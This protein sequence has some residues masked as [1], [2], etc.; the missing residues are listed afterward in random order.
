[1]VDMHCHLLFGVDDGPKMIE[2]SICILKKAKQ[3]GVTDMIVTPHAFSPRYH[4]S[5]SEI[6]RQIRILKDVVNLFDF[7]INL[8]MGQE[9]RLH[10]CLIENISNG[11]A[12]TLAGSRY[13]LLELP[14]EAVPTDT[15]TTIHSLL[16]KGV[17]PIIAHPERN[18]AIADKPEILE[19]LIRQGALAQV[20]AGSLSGYFGRQTQKVALQ[21]I[22][23]NLI[24]S[25][26]SDVHGI[27][28]RPLL[29]NEGLHFLEKK[30]LYEVV[31]IL[32]EN[33]ERILKD[34]MFIILDPEKPVLK[35]WWRCR[36]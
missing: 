7:Q 27:S 30:K 16:A 2:E 1:M 15:V 8:H 22:Q 5:K 26:G 19:L 28:K 31:N 24:H 11:T 33:N 32:L 20:T 4:V 35:K 29:F 10:D 21:L 9:V 6:E 23:A 12:M 17:I 14:F 18:R 36:R 25:Y 13:L 3:E 34:E